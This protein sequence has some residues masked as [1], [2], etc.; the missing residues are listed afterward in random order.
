MLKQYPN[1]FRVFQCSS[2]L[3]IA[4]SVTPCL[5][6]KDPLKIIGHRGGVV[7]DHHSEN[8]AGAAEAAIRRG[9]WMLEIDLDETK[10]GHIVV[11]HESF[12]DFGVNKMAAALTWSEI[13]GLT[14][15]ID[16]SHPLEFSQLAAICKGKVRLM[17]D[18]KQPGH[19]KSYYEQMEKVLK[20]N[21]L[22]K[23]A[24]FIGTA[25]TRDYFKGKARISLSEKELAKK[26]EAGESLSKG[27]F[28]FE[29]GTTINKQS[30]ELAQ[31]AHVPVV[32]SINE[33][34]YASRPDPMAAAHADVEKSKRLGV[35]LFQIDSPFD[36]WLH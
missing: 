7:D 17:I 28:L 18:T 4:L 27:Y 6:A 33:Y 10:D 32:V 8:S 13:Q 20:D 1:L 9:Y 31:K 16:Q 2:A 26:L 30:I 24:Y 29:H 25:E 22:L 15:N 35:A 12:R 23:S 21:H 5:Y 19:P 3:L 14:S 36:I 11:H 34:H